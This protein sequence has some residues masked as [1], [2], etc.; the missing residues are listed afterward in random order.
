MP[1]GPS[2]VILKEEVKQ[3]TGKI[4][5]SIGGNSKIDQNRLLNEKIN[6]FKS[7]GKHFLICFTGFTVRVHFLMFGTYRINEK[8]EQSVRLS[9]LFATGE[10]NLYACSIKILEGDVNAHYDWSTDVM[11][12]K[13]N[14]I[15]AKAKLKETP[16]K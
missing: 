15:N 11:N 12:E 7:W 2:I 10:I 8:K 6:S 1:E 14:P 4:I 16:D 5:I 13:W 3:F 9:I